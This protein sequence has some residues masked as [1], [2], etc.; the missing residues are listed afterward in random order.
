MAGQSGT[1]QI[2]ELLE[3]AVAGDKQAYD[4]IIDLAAERLQKLTGKMLAGYPH[5]RRW[6]DTSD[7]FQTAVIRLH[8][9]LSE[10][11]PESMQGFFGLAATQIRRTLID[12]ARHHFGPHGDAAH[13]HSDP[14]AA[15]DGGGIIG[16]QAA[17]SQQPETLQSWADFHEAVEELPEAERDVFQLVWYSGLEQKEIA[18]LLGVSVPTVK[19]RL[20]RA[21]VHLYESLQGVSPLDNEE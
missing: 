12:M 3:Q 18:G 7:V 13:H 14:G 2:Q 8:R 5:L 15:S 6:E 19:R 20:R 10:V 11:Q 16:R 9:S 4:D 21:R 17:K 1:T